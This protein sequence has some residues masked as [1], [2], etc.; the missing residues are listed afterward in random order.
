M[1]RIQFLGQVTGLIM[2]FY[3]PKWIDLDPG[4][5]DQELNNRII[6]MASD[7][8]TKF[9]QM[10]GDRPTVAPV[11]PIFNPTAGTFQKHN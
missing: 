1:E 6:A 2:Q 4:I 5:S 7:L 10:I 3:G 9:D 11:M 8:W